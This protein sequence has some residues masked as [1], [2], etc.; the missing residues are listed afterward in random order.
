MLR[1]AEEFSAAGLSIILHLNALTRADW[2]YWAKLLS[3]HPQHRYIAKEFQTGLM[4]PGK[5]TAALHELAALQEKLGRDL[6]PFII[7]G[8]RLARDLPRYFKDFTIIDSRPW[9]ATIYRQQFNLQRG[10]LISHSHLT[11]KGEMLDLLLQHNLEQYKQYIFNSPQLSRAS[12]EI[13]PK[14][15]SLMANSLHTPL[16]Q[17]LDRQLQFFD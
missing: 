12:N 16:Q 2:D 8:A 14:K 11:G 3:D 4:N 13:Q 7:G 17:R 9:M 15:K 1:C 5:S 6:H 10:K